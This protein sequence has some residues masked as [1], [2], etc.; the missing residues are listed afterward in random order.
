MLFRFLFKPREPQFAL[1]GEIRLRRLGHSDAAIFCV[2]IHELHYEDFRDRFNGLVSDEWLDKYID[3][4]LDNAIVIGAFI[5]DHLVA[6]AELHAGGYLAEGEGESAFSVASDWRRKGLGTILLKALLK[7]ATE[8]DISTIIVE[9]GP[10][11]HAMKALARKFG[12][13]MRFTGDQSVGRIN[14]AEGLRLA[15]RR[16]VIKSLPALATSLAATP[17]GAQPA[18]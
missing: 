11:N 3:R 7:A 13:K 17:G 18:I 6:V 4:S 5:G 1:D 2:H 15:G 14:V 9:T 8:N 16:S 10:Q 12:A